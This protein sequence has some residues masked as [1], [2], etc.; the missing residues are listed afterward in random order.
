V[1]FGGDLRVLA[2]L[3]RGQPDAATHRERLEG[4]YAP[5]AGQYDRFRERLLPGRDELIEALAAALPD[6]GG[7]LVELGAGTGR[8]AERFGA[9]LE[10]FEAVHLV[11]LCEALAALA[12]R[13]HAAR[14]QVAVTLADATTWRPPAPVDCV[15]FSYA[16]TMIP[17]WFLAI[18]NALAMLRPGGVLGVVDFYVARRHPAAGD[19][20]HGRFARHFWPLWFG[21]D[22]VHPSPD[23]L[24]YLRARCD[25]VALREARAALPWLPFARVPWYCYLG[26][27]RG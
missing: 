9:R 21:H 16:L 22:G 25:T 8:N 2:A 12:R 23:H 1:T 7:T 6:A 24:P 14:P 27:K 26:R 4:F 19:A 20:R 18:D 3:A 13:R 11:D 10:R 5:Q 15:Y 17:D